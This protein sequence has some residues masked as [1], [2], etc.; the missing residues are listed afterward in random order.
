MVLQNQ[1]LCSERSYHCPWQYTRNIRGQ[2]SLLSMRKRVSPSYGQAASA[3]SSSV[4]KPSQRQRGLACLAWTQE[5]AAGTSARA[6]VSVDRSRR[7]IIHAI[8]AWDSRI[9]QQMWGSGQ[10]DDQSQGCGTSQG[11]LH[12]WLRVVQELCVP[13]VGHSAYYCQKVQ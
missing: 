6:A 2:S 12:A 11:R 13:L 5:A 3:Q 7:G 1:A 8:M 9:A 4:G 10:S